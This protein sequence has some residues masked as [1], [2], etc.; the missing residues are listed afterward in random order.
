MHT[1]AFF[2][3]QVIRQILLAG[4]CVLAITSIAYAQEIGP[5]LRP[6][7]ADKNEAVDA[8]DGSGAKKTRRG[9]TLQQNWDLNA[10]D[11]V[12]SASKKRQLLSEAPSTIH[13]ITSDDIKRCV[14]FKQ[15]SFLILNEIII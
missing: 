12:F 10:A 8:V 11:V 14:E 6:P 5:N 13:V 9:N 15:M 3:A 2:C 7:G 1:Q 4:L